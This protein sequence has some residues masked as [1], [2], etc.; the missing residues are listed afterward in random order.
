M[1]TLADGILSSPEAIGSTEPVVPLKQEPKPGETPTEAKKP[2]ELFAE[3][4]AALDAQAKELKKLQE[5]VSAYDEDRKRREADERLRSITQ[6]E[7]Q[8]EPQP[9]VPPAGP[10]DFDWGN[11]LKSIE[12]RARKI[13]Q[14]ELEKK[15][16]AQA[17][18]QKKMD[19]Q[20]AAQNFFATRER[21]FKK[22]PELFAG[23]E[24][25]LSRTMTVG[26]QT[27]A[28]T[29]DMIGNDDAWETG[30][31]MLAKKQGDKKKIEA[32]F[33]GS[34]SIEPMRDLG[35]GAIPG[36]VKDQT[37]S[38]QTQNIELD[39]TAKEYMKQRGMTYEQALEAIKYARENAYSMTS[40]TTIGSR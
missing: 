5:T 6:P 17:E 35:S 32:Y 15:D 22:N 10:D 19:G 3:Y 14:E 21:V 40:P 31:L 29:A 34:Q 12:A 28:M 25:E 30:A 13:A 36:Q 27:G 11:P 38:T 26:Y 2:E 1:T 18:Y 7:P 33:K 16:K 37:K 39:E 20:R 8:P 4:K 9:V 24:D 23:Y